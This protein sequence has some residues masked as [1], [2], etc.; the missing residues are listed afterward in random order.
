[1]SSISETLHT[2]TSEVARQWLPTGSRTEPRRSIRYSSIPAI[3]GA[4]DI[5]LVMISAVLTGTLY[6]SI[7]EVDADL[8][9]YVMTG[10]VV[11]AIF[12]PIFHN[13]GL[14]SPAAL[15][16]WKFQV[17]NILA[18]WTMT[19]LMFASVA[20]ALK[21]GSDFSRGAVLLFGIVG[22]LA[23]VLHR[24][25]W[26]III[27]RAL[28]VGVLRGRRSILLYMY[29]S[30]PEADVIRDVIPDFVR[31]GYDIIQFFHF[32]SDV[33]N[34]RVIEK[35]IEFTR[36]SDI[37]EIFFAADVQ[38]WSEISQMAQELCVIPLPLTLLPDECTA[39]L[40]QRPSRQFGRTVGVEFSRAP[41]SLT[42]RLS[43]RL[44]DIVCSIAAIVVLLPMFLIVA[45]AIKLDSPGP[46]L[47]MQTRHGFNGRRFKIIKF[48][49][50]TVLEDGTTIPQAVRGDSRV[51]RIGSWLRKTSIDE[52]PQ[53]FNVLGGDM[54]IVGPR[55]HAVAHD[56]H[57]ADLISKY[58]F[59]HHVKP[60][61]T[62]WAQ[63]HG[64]R[65]E[66]PTVRSMKERVDRDI[67]YV[68]NWSLPLDLQIILRT[69]V[70]VM[71][72]RNAY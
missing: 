59:R 34:K 6:H 52:I 38:R 16:N 55:P 2:A 13:R 60:G 54:S 3:V 5:L 56:N 30:P 29:E 27:E 31:S 61:I 66:T 4:L 8:T 63:V 50:M 25:L 33:P 18:V 17:R 7:Q 62:G 68:D 36:G 10:C 1:M 51:T 24:A 67:W 48:R 71:R 28:K 49:T 20:F 37:E 11:V 40:F 45:L 70:E 14:Y 22:L 9:R 46:V 65:G 19:F 47:F 26:R 64:Y 32:G 39:T 35:I 21:V 53:F 12:V 57:Y 15:M 58:A 41:L 44:L 72:R 23:I 69:A 42:E 43:K